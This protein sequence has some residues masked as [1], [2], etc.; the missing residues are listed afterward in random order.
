[1]VVW[2]SQLLSRHSFHSEAGRRGQSGILEVVPGL[3]VAVMMMVGVHEQ[4]GT[5]R[6]AVY[7]GLVC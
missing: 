3:K 5:F 1:M 6:G 7:Y 2:T 4:V